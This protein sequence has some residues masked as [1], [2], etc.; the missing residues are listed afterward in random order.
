MST[1]EASK[2]D[3]FVIDVL[4]LI[5]DFNKSNMVDSS[6]FMYADE[7]KEMNLS[8]LDQLSIHRDTKAWLEKCNWRLFLFGGKV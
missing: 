4:Y 7:Q 6:Y 1:K 2:S 3:R 8:W 5:S